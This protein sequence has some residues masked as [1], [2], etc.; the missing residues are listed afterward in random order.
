V[1]LARFSHFSDIKPVRHAANEPTIAL[2]CTREMVLVAT[3]GSFRSLLPP[4]RCRPWPGG[5]NET[6]RIYFLD[7]RISARC[8]AYGTGAAARQAAHHR[9]S[10]C[11]N[12]SVQSKWTALFEQRLPELGWMP[13]NP[14]AVIAGR[15]VSNPFFLCAVNG[16]LRAACHR[17][18]I[19]ATRGSQ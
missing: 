8:A 19:R 6:A 4:I 15:E 11:Y 12:A 17:A 10:G 2:A 9:F 3:L 16:L 5:G 1:Y 14:P 7:W 18:R 13:A